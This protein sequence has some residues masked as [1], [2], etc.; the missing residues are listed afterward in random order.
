MWTQK[1]ALILAFGFSFSSVFA[2][3]DLAENHLM[4]LNQKT[5]RVTSNGFFGKEWSGFTALDLAND[6]AVYETVNSKPQVQIGQ[7]HFLA[8]WAVWRGLRPL[9]RVQLLSFGPGERHLISKRDIRWEAKRCADTQIL[10]N[11]SESFYF[12]DPIEFLPDGSGR[13][14][15]LREAM[16]TDYRYFVMFSIN[17]QYLP[18]QQERVPLRRQSEET[19]DEFFL[20]KKL[21]ISDWERKHSILGTYGFFEVSAEHRLYGGKLLGTQ[22][23]ESGVGGSAGAGASSWIHF[24]DY[25]EKISDDLRSK[26]KKYAPMRWPVYYDERSHKPHSFSMPSFWDAGAPLELGR[27]ILQMRIYWNACGEKIQL[28][29]VVPKGST[30]QAGPT[31]PFRSDE[32]KSTLEPIEVDDWQD[33]A[34]G[35]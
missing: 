12:D 28:K 23:R 8:Y 6:F 31:R 27:N 11:D 24:D 33:Q 1:F 32:G 3:G 22:A 9:E 2:E 5:Y 7:E 17:S 4:D 18:S 10:S 34:N 14:L 35:I 15:P 26:L 30:I 13:I 16:R 20:R 29:A 19:E 25:F 21:S